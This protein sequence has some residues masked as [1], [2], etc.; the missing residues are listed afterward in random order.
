MQIIDAIQKFLSILDSDTTE[1]E[2]I[3]NLMTSL[4]ELAFLSHNISYETNDKDHP[5]P[6]ER[7][8][9]KTLE[10]VRKRFSSLGFYN[11]AGGISDKIS[12]CDMLVGD[13]ISDI[14]E[15]ADDLNEVLWYFNNTSND[16]ALFY[17]K[18]DFAAHWGRILRELQLYLHD[19]WW[20][21]Q[22]TGVSH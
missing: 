9:S 1:E 4:D 10:K 17:F 11:V 13:A 6:P 8:C 22:L 14:A 16:N 2:A 5:S 15:I 3:R 20:Q 12:E 19:R 18:L 7:N 21:S